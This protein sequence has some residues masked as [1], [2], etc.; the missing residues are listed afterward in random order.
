MAK[1]LTTHITLLILCLTVCLSACT[2]PEAPTTAEDTPIYIGVFEPLTGDSGA[3]GSQEVLGI[4]FAHSLEP[5]ITIGDTVREIKLV[6]VDNQSSADFAPTAAN[7]LVDTAPLSLVLGSYGSSASI[8]ASP[9]FAEHGLP[10]LGITCT[11]PAVTE[12]NEHYFRLCF[13]DS[14]QGSA[15][16]NFARE[17]FDARTA[18]I[19]TEDGNIYDTG[20]AEFFTRSFEATGGT[21]IAYFL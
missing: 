15:L 12:G 11:N 6:I 20:L 17:E 16:S 14:F 21:V 3:G 4:E 10:A 9:V 2:S 19:L 5:S 18:Y 7:T 1:Q 8:A 13:V